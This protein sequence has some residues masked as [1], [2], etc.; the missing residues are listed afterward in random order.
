MADISKAVSANDIK[1]GTSITGVDGTGNIQAHFEAGKDSTS[2]S[3]SD[4]QNKYSSRFDDINYYFFQEDNPLLVGLEAYYHLDEESGT[5]VDQING[6]DLTDNNTVGYTTGVSTALSNAA[7]FVK[8]NLESLSLGD[9]SL[10]EL[11]PGNSDW[12][13]ACWIKLD[14]SDFSSN[15]H[16]F[17]VWKTSPSNDRE[18]LL[19]WKAGHTKFRFYTS[20]NGQVSTSYLPS[21]K[22]DFVADTWYHL[23]FCHDASNDQ[24]LLYIN[25]DLDASDS[26]SDGVYQGGGDLRIGASQNT[27]DYTDGAIDDW[28]MWSRV[29]PASEISDLYNSGDGYKIK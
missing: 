22:N 1:N 14:S 7:N 26:Y 17:G 19:Y 15:Q 24:R 10:E 5:R 9:A 3:L 6:K 16:V 2:P 12:S 8:S 28:G 20:Y 27:S 4:I 21:D 29:L 11:S 23:V 18:Y 25:G 13:V